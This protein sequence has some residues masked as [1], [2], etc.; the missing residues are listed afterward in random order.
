MERGPS[1]AEG[2]PAPIPRTEEGGAVPSQYVGP[3]FSEP[4]TLVL[5]TTPV[6]KRRNDEGYH[7]EWTGL[8]M[9]AINSGTYR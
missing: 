4:L 3:G 8:Q 2:R 9:N 5:L 6:W 1:I 7:Y